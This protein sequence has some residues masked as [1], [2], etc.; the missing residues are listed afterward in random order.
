MN[1]NNMGSLVT[2][3]TINLNNLEGLKQTMESVFKQS[4]SDYEYIIIDGGSTDGSREYI[5]Q[6]VEKLVYWVSEKDSGVYAAMNKGIRQS[7]GEFLM[8]LNSGD[9]FFN[10]KS[11]ETLIA[12]SEGY[13]LVYGNIL[14]KEDDKE[15]VKNYP[16]ELSFKYFLADTLPHPATL[17]RSSLLKK[18]GLF[19]EQLKIVSDWEF[20]LYSVCSLNAKYKYVDETISVFPYNGLSSVA[21]N[22]KLISEERRA[23]LSLR[24]ASFLEDYKEAERDSNKLKL[25]ENSRWFRLRRHLKKIGI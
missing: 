5:E 8:F 13:D 6:H 11:M 7:K 18:F 12:R 19:N 23:V 10:Q 22:Q 21:S 2:I 17:I 14:V 25:L 20:F 3:I 24:Y 1:K 9:Y 16:A 4:F 15:W